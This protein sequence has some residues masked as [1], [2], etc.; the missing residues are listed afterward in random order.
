[1]DRFRIFLNFW[2][3]QSFL[4]ESSVTPVNQ[5][6]PSSRDMIVS[7]STPNR[8]SSTTFLANKE[9]LPSQKLY[10]VRPRLTYCTQAFCV[11]YVYICR[12]RPRSPWSKKTVNA[13]AIKKKVTDQEAR[14]QKTIKKT[15]TATKSLWLRS[16]LKRLRLRPRSLWL[17]SD[18]EACDC[19]QKSL[20]LRSLSKRLR[21][22][23]RSPG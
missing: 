16:P 15:A 23:P 5:A 11:W 14:G 8:I 6:T 1:V 18:K 20:W 7:N 13:T 17:R 3:V 21:L 19:D 2:S 12:L 22:R 10:F 4:R 9:R